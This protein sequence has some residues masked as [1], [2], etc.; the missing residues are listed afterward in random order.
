MAV[1]LIGCLLRNRNEVEDVVGNTGQGAEILRAAN[2]NVVEIVVHVDG[3]VDHHSLGDQITF[4]EICQITDNFNVSRFM[5][6]GH[7]GDFYWGS[8]PS[9]ITVIVKKVNFDLL[10]SHFRVEMEFYSKVSHARLVP[11][12]GYCADSENGKY[13]IYKNAENGDLTNFLLL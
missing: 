12:L 2:P 9:G 4:Q 10:V 13:L 7:F 11:L 8:R 5:N 3:N 1:A 6:H